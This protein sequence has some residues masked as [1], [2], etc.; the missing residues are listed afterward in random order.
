MR[1]KRFVLACLAALLLPVSAEADQ[2]AWTMLKK[3]IK[4]Y[5]NKRFVDAERY[6]R[7]AADMDSRCGDAHF[8]LG[9]LAERRGAGEEALKHYDRI[10][11]ESGAYP[12]GA[13]RAGLLALKKGDLKEAEKKLKIVCEHRPS[14]GAWMQLASI[15]L[16]AEKFKEAEASLQAGE[17][18][19]RD[20]LD[21]VELKGRLYMETDRPKLAVTAYDRILKVI[22]ADNNARFLRATAYLELG[23]GETAL[24]DFAG[25]LE[26]DPWHRGTLLAL[27]RLHGDDKSRRAEVKEYERRLEILKK[28][29]P[30]VRQAKGKSSKKLP[31]LKGR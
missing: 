3:G 24:R 17:K 20:N 1:K 27:V 6:F 10:K 16:D 9:M 22:P 15:Q 11:E 7:A 25:V 30:R 4:L 19:S 31:P 23:L 12:L 28:N 18:L 2:S 13:E 26:R 5:R 29:P 8:Y 21:L 14:A